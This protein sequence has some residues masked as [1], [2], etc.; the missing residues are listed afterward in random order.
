[1]KRI[2]A[3]LAVTLPL[4]AVAAWT[5]GAGKPIPDTPSMRSSGDFGAQLV[6]TASEK[7]FRRV[8][9]S[10]TGT[11]RLQ[12]VDTVRQGQSISAVIVFSGCT[13]GVDGACK[14]AVD[15]VLQSP[16]GSR[17]PA[18]SGPVWSKA[19]QKPPLLLLGDASVTLGF[20]LDDAPGRYTLLATVT[21][22]IAGRTLRLAL[23]F[24]VT[25]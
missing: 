13:P 16:D 21:D 23:P 14:V 5:D 7:E 17:M 12:A 19:P 4:A 9:H 24:A 25:K 10:T 8:W 18:G 20:G 22:A 1:M 3:S 6:L 2:L 15:F 11:P